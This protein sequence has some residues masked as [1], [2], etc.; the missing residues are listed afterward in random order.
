MNI[1]WLVS[2]LG[3]TDA[4]TRCPLGLKMVVPS[5]IRRQSS[6]DQEEGSPEVVNGSLDSVESYEQDV[7]KVLKNIHTDA[8]DLTIPGECDSLRACYLC[9]M[10]G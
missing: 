5:S 2:L 8:E 7:T 9:C 4:F 1:L 10:N 3:T 6:I